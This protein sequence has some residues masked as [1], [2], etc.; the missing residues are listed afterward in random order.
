MKWWNYD[1]GSRAYVIGPWDV[2]PKPH[3]QHPVGVQIQCCAVVRGRSDQVIRAE[4]ITVNSAHIGSC[5]S[6]SSHCHYLAVMRDLLAASLLVGESTLYFFLYW[7]ARGLY[8]GSGRLDTNSISSEQWPQFKEAV[9]N[10]AD[11]ENRSSE[12]SNWGKIVMKS[13][14]FWIQNSI[15]FCKLYFYHRGT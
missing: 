3:D 11:R 2:G 13:D 4:I 10:F 7:Y 14:N 12:C 15:H 6:V 8:L 5:Q 1:T 9:P